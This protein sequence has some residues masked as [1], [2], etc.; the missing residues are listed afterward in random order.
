MKILYFKDLSCPFK[1]GKVCLNP[2]LEPMV[3]DKPTITGG[4]ELWAATTLMVNLFTAD[5]DVNAIALNWW[6]LTTM[7]IKHGEYR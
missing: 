5:L 6:T 7:G 1:Y 3:C 2:E 4:F